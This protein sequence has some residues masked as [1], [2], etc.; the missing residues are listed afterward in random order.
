MKNTT[1]EMMTVSQVSELIQSGASLY[2]AASENC[3]KQLPCGQWIGGT[4]PYFMTETGGLISND[5]I[6]V[7]KISTKIKNVNILVYDQK[8]LNQIPRNYYKNGVSLILI[9][10]FSEIHLQYAEECTTWLGV[11]DQPLVG[12]VTGI[13]LSISTETPK[14]VN[15]QTG[16]I[17]LNHALVMHIELP[18]DL[19]ASANIINIFEQSDGD[20]IEFAETGFDAK[21]AFVNGQEVI[22][23][24]YI[25]KNKIDTQL[26]LVADYMG[27]MIN[28]SFRD[29][30]HKNQKVR[31]YAPVFSGV[32]YQIAKPFENYEKQFE[33]VLKKQQIET[34]FFACNCILNFL[35]AN[36]DGKKS[37]HVISA[38]T[39]GE[40]A[41]MLLNQTF[42]YITIGPRPLDRK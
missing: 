9:P 8:N 1:N 13:D 26:P 18:D 24:D 34:P 41:Y 19:I 16:E 5:K 23:A 27:A 14:V 29:I 37:G 2:L 10:A 25:L 32:K 17:L 4:I 35:Y 39:F 40:I 28:V 30:D 7:T 15:G 12:W 31:F 42:I 21:T 6:L 3:L 22:L 33:S 20:F 36:L 11:F 38:M